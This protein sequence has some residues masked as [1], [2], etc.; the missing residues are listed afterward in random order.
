MPNRLLKFARYS[1][2]KTLKIFHWEAIAAWKYL[3]TNFPADNQ[4]TVFGRLLRWNIKNLRFDH[5]KAQAFNMNSVSQNNSLHEMSLMS[6]TTRQRPLHHFPAWWA[7]LV[8]ILNETSAINVH[9]NCWCIWAA[10]LIKSSNKCSG[11]TWHKESCSVDVEKV[12]SM[13]CKVHK[14]LSIC[15]AKIC[16]YLVHNVCEIKKYLRGVLVVSLYRRF[17]TWTILMLKPVSLAKP[18]RIFRQGFGEMSNDALKAR[19]CCVVKIVL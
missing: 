1:R 8:N 12:C 2:E 4:T 19:L 7:A 13:L 17:Q 5:T 3:V 14:Q 16:L 15:D 11:K 10:K 6:T 18:S 9:Q